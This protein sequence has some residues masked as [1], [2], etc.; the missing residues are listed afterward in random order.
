MADR[1]SEQTILEKSFD[2]TFDVLKT[3]V[4]GSDGSNLQ[5]LKVDASGNLKT[6]IV[7]AGGEAVTVTGGKLDVN[8]SA[9]LSGAAI[10]ISGATTA[11]GVAIVDGSGNQIT[12]FGGGTQYTDAGTPPANPVGP[13]I[14]WNEGGTWRTVS[15]AKPLPVTASVSTAGLATDTKQDTGNSSLSSID[16]KTP[17]LGQALAAASTPVVLTAAQLSTLTPPAAITGFATS[18]KQDTGNTSLSSIDGKL[19]ALGQ[20]LAAASVPVILPSATITTLTPPAAITGFATSAK[21]DTLLTELQLKADLTETQPVSLASVPSHAVTNAGTFAVQATEADGANVT[22]GAK[23][24]AKSTA[25]DATSVTAMQVLKQISA[26]VQAPPSQAVTNAGTFA[27]QVTSAPTTAVTGTFY[28]A[29]QPV[30]FTGSTD[31]ATQTT[32]A[33]IKAKTDNIPAQG[34]ALAAASLPVVLTAAQITTLTPPAAITG[35]ATSAKQDTIDTSI[36]TL[37]KPAS[38]LA[39]V[40]TVGT[41]SAV[42]AITNALPAGT[43]AIGKLAANSGV[44]I[45]DVDILSIAAG[46]NN[47]GDVDVASFT[48][49][50]PTN[51]TSTAYE[52]NRV[53]KASAGTLWGLSGYNSKTSAQFIQIHNTTSLP[54]D[55]AVPVVIFTV[56]ASSNFALDFGIR[57]RALSTGITICNSSTGPTKT[58]GSADCWFDVQFT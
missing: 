54:A 1:T 21:Q 34:Q 53:A 6:S 37:L 20:A 8:A 28:Q 49:A 29:T 33:L 42:T 55:T 24:D 5:R 32:L 58:I 48:I 36:N 31:V 12:S 46:N 44:D 4:Y 18:A 52:T 41:V 35:Y 25:T 57:G 50:A 26:S 27:V 22:L 10:P 14:Q 9:T 30:S 16:S 11:V 17:A 3:G 13:T 51:S 2:P 43:N 38:T 56:P 23:T 40:T 39:A 7:D 15:T 19:P 45:G 47:I